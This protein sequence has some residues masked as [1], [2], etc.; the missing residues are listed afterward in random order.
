LTYNPSMKKLLLLLILSVGFTNYSFAGVEDISLKCKGGQI[1]TVWIK[2]GEKYTIPENNVVKVDWT[3]PSNP[4]ENKGNM[5]V[6]GESSNSV[7]VS[8]DIGFRYSNLLEDGVYK[9][10][11]TEPTSYWF[12]KELSLDGKKGKSSFWVKREDGQIWRLRWEIEADRPL[13]YKYNNY[14]TP[15]NATI[16]RDLGT[17][18]PKYNGCEKFTQLF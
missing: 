10:Y 8:F 11:D 5:F 12:S 3:H 15:D 9:L 16:I 17:F 4:Q 2:G 18:M 7:K 14:R 1:S 13:D 6:I